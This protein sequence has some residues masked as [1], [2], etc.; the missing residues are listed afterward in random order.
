MGTA[1]TRIQELFGML[2]RRRQYERAHLPFMQ[3]LVDFDIVIEVGYAQEQGAPITIKQLLLL[4][5]E[6]T[7]ARTVRRRLD[8]L[9]YSGVILQRRKVTDQ[10]ST[11]LALSVTSSRSLEKYGAMLASLTM[12][13]GSN[14]R[15]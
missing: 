2:R 11:A 3:S 4:L 1:V 13:E 14:P 15:L 6:L 10:R 7:S 5:G 8:R 9:I 12:L